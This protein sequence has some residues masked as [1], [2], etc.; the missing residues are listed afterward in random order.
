MFF[1]PKNCSFRS[2]LFEGGT[3]FF[4]RKAHSFRSAFFTG[5][6]RSVFS[7]QEV[8]FSFDTFRGRCAQRFSF[9]RAVA[10][11]WHF[12]LAACAAFF[13]RQ[14]STPQ[15]AF[16]AGETRS[17]FRPQHQQFSLTIFA[18]GPESA[19][20]SQPA[21]PWARG[22]CDKTQTVLISASDIARTFSFPFLFSCFSIFFLTRKLEICSEKKNSLPLFAN[23]K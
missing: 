20:F 14:N 17:I 1:V 10:F 12:S 16:F 9:A 2:T 23:E 18:Q 21:Q 3:A 5:G 19:N 15:S 11:I 7:P 13:A 8:Q 6:M 4:A 22:N